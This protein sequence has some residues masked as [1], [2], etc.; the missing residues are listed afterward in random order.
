MLNFNLKTNEK[1]FIL[2]QNNQVVLTILKL[3]QSRSRSRIGIN[4]SKKLVIKSAERY[5]Y[6]NQSSY[7]TKTSIYKCI[8][9]NTSLL[10]MAKPICSA[11]YGALHII[12]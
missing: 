12:F 5:N 7:I 2:Y 11:L 10:D 6:K 3:T 1:I 4:A 8:E 9:A